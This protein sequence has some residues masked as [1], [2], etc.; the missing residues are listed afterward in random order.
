MQIGR[1]G[2]EK[3]PFSGDLLFILKKEQQSRKHQR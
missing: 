3:N 1:L 2:K